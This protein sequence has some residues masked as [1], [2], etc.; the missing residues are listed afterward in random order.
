MANACLSACLPACLLLLYVRTIQPQCIWAKPDINTTRC[1]A[2]R[3]VLLSV[4]ASVTAVYWHTTTTRCCML[5]LRL[6]AASDDQLAQLVPGHGCPAP[7]VMTRLF[8]YEFERPEARCVV[9]VKASW[10]RA[11]DDGGA[12]PRH[13]QHSHGGLGSTRRCG[14]QCTGIRL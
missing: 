10:Q 14:A 12:A 4:T 2:V 3:Y 1:A 11:I 6:T 7:V 9:L 8:D 13:T 5:F